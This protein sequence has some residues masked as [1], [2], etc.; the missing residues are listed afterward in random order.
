M[1]LIINDLVPGSL[2]HG[3]HSTLSN[4]IDLIVAMISSYCQPTSSLWSN[5]KNY[6]FFS[7][8]SKSLSGKKWMLFDEMSILTKLI[9]LPI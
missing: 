7:L 9:S 4:L 3:L 6:K 1:F 8:G 2:V 5:N